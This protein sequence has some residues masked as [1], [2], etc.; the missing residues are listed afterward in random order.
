MPS[1]VA[2]KYTY[3]NVQI[4]RVVDGDTVESIVDLGFRVLMEMPLRIYGINTPE[5][6]QP[7]YDK[8]TDALRKILK[9]RPTTRNPNPTCRVSVNTIKS[10]EKYGRYLAEIF[11]SDGT[12]VAERMI[13]TGFAIPYLGGAR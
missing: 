4:V 6:G 12:S 1:E 5:R 10:H 2:P 13:A 9:M 7:N 11:L 3:T 8:A